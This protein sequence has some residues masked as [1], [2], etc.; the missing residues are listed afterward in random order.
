MIFDR[1]DKR[2]HDVILKLPRCTPYTTSTAI[3]W[4]R[5]I[6]LLT[7][8]DPASHLD[9]YTYDPASTDRQLS[10]THSFNTCPRYQ[11]LH[12]LDPTHA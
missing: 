11:H 12:P 4:R 7:D 3:K 2:H 1:T 5:R 8:I 9:P 6:I 10:T